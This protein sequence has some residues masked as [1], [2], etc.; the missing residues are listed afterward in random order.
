MGFKK[1]RF[2]ISI[3]ILPIL[4]NFEMCVHY[5]FQ[6][7]NICVKEI[8]CHGGNQMDIQ[9]EISHLNGFAGMHT[10]FHILHTYPIVQIVSADLVF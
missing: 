6:V 4:N 7:L 1:T 8:T 10:N 3:Q 9:Y 2:I 5:C